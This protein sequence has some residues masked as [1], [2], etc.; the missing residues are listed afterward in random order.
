MIL[1]DACN[2]SYIPRSDFPKYNEEE[3]EIGGYFVVNGV[4]KL[5]RLL[6]VTRRN[7]VGFEFCNCGFSLLP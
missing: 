2:L 4:E 7:Y 3:R 6:I 5:L 1:S